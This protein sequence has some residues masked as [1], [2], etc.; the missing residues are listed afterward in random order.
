MTRTTCKHVEAAVAAH[1]NSEL[2][3]DERAA[4]AVHLDVCES[5]RELAEVWQALPEVTREATLEPLTDELEQRLLRME[6]GAPVDGPSTRSRPSAALLFALAAAVVLALGITIWLTLGSDPSNDEV[7]DPALV[8]ST[9]ARAGDPLVDDQGQ[10]QLQPDAPDRRVLD[11]GPGIRIVVDDTAGIGL[12]GPGE[13]PLAERV[14]LERGCALVEVEAGDDGVELFLETPSGVVVAREAVFSVE[15]AAS[16]TAWIEVVEGLVYALDS[17]G[18]EIHARLSAGEHASLDDLRSGT[19]PV[20]TGEDGADPNV[21][22]LELQ[23]GPVELEPTLDE[24]LKQARAHRK[25]RD[26]A[27]ATASYERLITSYP[28]SAAARTSLVALG[29]MELGS[30]GRA[31]SALS[32]F[33]AYLDAAPGGALAEE[34]RAGKVRALARLSRT[35]GLIRAVSDYLRAHPGGRATSEMLRRR[36]DAHRRLGSCAEAI[37]DY[38]RVVDRWPGSTEAEL[39]AKG[40]DACSTAP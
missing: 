40:L 21:A 27:R 33:E 5:C 2:S 20:T 22:K 7:G 28:G 37:R 16:E 39:A 38:R 17:D 13:N 29:Q 15:V 12:D 34:A 35:R 25:A 1:V 31:G 19:T 6:G 30:M 10:N 18:E 11:I 23:P 8:A 14:A 3:E 36:A 24:L 26:F 4:I 9:E 32:H